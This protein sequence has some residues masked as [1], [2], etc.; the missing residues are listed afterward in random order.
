MTARAIGSNQGSSG[1]PRAVSLFPSHRARTVLLAGT[2]LGAMLL[3]SPAAAGPVTAVPV[4]GGAAPSAAPTGSRPAAP[5]SIKPDTSAGLAQRVRD[6]TATADAIR[7]AQAAQAAARAAGGSNLTPNGLSKGGLEVYGGVTADP[8]TAQNNNPLW[9]NAGLPSET[10]NADGSVTVSIKQTD[11]KATLTWNTF[12]VG[13]KTTVA[14]DQTDSAGVARKD[15][16]ALN[17]VED[18]SLAPSVIRGKIQAPGEVYIINRNGVIFS[19]T[20]QVN[21]AGLLASTLDFSVPVGAAAVPYG[22]RATADQKNIAFGSLTADQ[23]AAGVDTTYS[24]LLGAFRSDADQSIGQQVNN[25]FGLGRT[26]SLTNDTLNPGSIVIEAGAT[27]TTPKV[28]LTNAASSN[29]VSRVILVAPKIVNGGMI[30]ADQ[31]QVILAAGADAFF[32]D[33]GGGKL[34]VFVRGRDKTTTGELGSLPLIESSITNAKNGLIAVPRGDITFVADKIEQDGV[35]EVSTSVTTPGTVNLLTRTGLRFLFGAGSSANIPSSL[36]SLTLGSVT[37][38]DGAVIANLPDD[39]TGGGLDGIA[40]ADP[41]TPPVVTLQGRFITLGKGAGIMAPGGTVNFLDT[42]AGSNFSPLNYDLTSPTRVGRTYLG[43]NSFVDVSGQAVTLSADRNFITVNLRSYELRDSPL[44]REDGPSNVYGQDVVIDLRVTGTRDDGSTWVGTPLADVSAAVANLTRGIDEKLSAGGTINFGIFSQLG[45]SSTGELVAMSGS[46]LNVAGGYVSYTPGEALTTKLVTADGRLVDIGAASRDVVYQGLYGADNVDHPTWGVGDSYT[47][48]FTEGTANQGYFEG[49]N[50]GKISFTGSRLVSDAAIYGGVVIGQRQRL[51]GSTTSSLYAGDLIPTAATL[52]ITTLA[53]SSVTYIP[54]ATGTNASISTASGAAGLKFVAGSATGLAGLT[55]DFRPDDALPATAEFPTS[56]LSVDGLSGD[57]GIGNL[58][59]VAGDITLGK[60]VSLKLAPRGTLDLESYGRI[61]EVVDAVT[62]KPLPCTVCAGGRVVNGVAFV[63]DLDGVEHRLAQRSRAAVTTIDGTITTPGG[64]VIL[65]HATTTDSGTDR[66]AVRIGSGAVIDVSGQYLNDYGATVLGAPPVIGGGSITIGNLNEIAPNAYDI[67]SGAQLLANGGAWLQ[68]GGDLAFG[69]GGAITLNGPSAGDSAALFGGQIV[70][71]AFGYAAPALTRA[72]GK[73]GSLSFN[74][75]SGVAFGAL[76]PNSRPGSL[77]ID[78]A[79]LTR[80]GFSSVSVKAIVNNVDP[81]LTQTADQTQDY[82]YALSFAP[83]KYDFGIRNRILDA[84][85][86]SVASGAD[87]RA[88]SHVGQVDALFRPGVAINL[89]TTGR[90]YVPTGVDITLDRASAFALNGGP[91]LYFDG[92]ITAPASKIS[93]YT[94]GATFVQR[95]DPADYF[96]S[97]VSVSNVIDFG[98][99]AK[100]D[101]RG[102]ASIYKDSAGLRAGEVLAGGDVS[103]TT[104]NGVVWLRPGSEIDVSGTSGMV[105]AARAEDTMFGVARG[106]R[107]TSLVGEAGSVTLIGTEGLFVD[108]TLTG[109]AGGAGGMGGTLTVRLARQ[110]GLNTYLTGVSSLDADRVVTRTATANQ[111]DKDWFWFAP[112]ILETLD[113]AQ[114]GTS[115]F[116]LATDANGIR[117][118]ALGSYANNAVQLNTA[119]ATDNFAAGMDG[120]GFIAADTISKGGFSD[121]TLDARRAVRFTTDVT[122][123]P[124]RSLT[125]RTPNV[126]VIGAAKIALSATRVAFD[127]PQE[128]IGTTPGVRNADGTTS[129]GLTPSSIGDTLGNKQRDTENSRPDNVLGTLDV[130]AGVIDVSGNVAFGNGTVQIQSVAESVAATGTYTGNGLAYVTNAAGTGYT[131]YYRPAVSRNLDGFATINFLSATDIRVAASIGSRFVVPPSYPAGHALYT[132]GNL[133]L[134]AGQLYPTLRADNFAPNN[135]AFRIN[136][137]ADK[138][139]TIRSNGATPPVPYAPFGQLTIAAGTIDQGGVVRAPQG[140]IAL[141]STD[142]VNGK[143]ILRPGSL[144]SASLEGA[145]IPA[146]SIEDDG[147]TWAFSQGANGGFFATLANGTT[148]AQTVGPFTVPGKGLTISATNI[149]AQVGSVIDLSGGG[150]LYAK[151]FVPGT[152]GSVDVATRGPNR[153]AIVPARAGLPGSLV[154]ED[155]QQIYIGEGAGVPAGF[156]TLL[157]ADYATLPG[158]YL[159]TRTDVS[160][161]LPLY[162]VDRPDGA[163]LV[164]GYLTLGGEREQKW[165]QFEIDAP[166]VVRSR[167]GYQ[168]F[169]ANQYFTSDAYLAAAARTAGAAVDVP[170]LPADGGSLTLNALG[171]VNLLGTSRFLAMGGARVGVGTIT[172]DKLAVIDSGADKASLLAQNYTLLLADQLSAFFS[173]GSLAVAGKTALLV[174]TEV[175]PLSAAQI[176]LT[177]DTN[178]T[179]A[180]GSQIVAKGVFDQNS[181]D[182]INI[183]FVSIYAP[184]TRIGDNTKFTSSGALRMGGNA[185][186][187]IPD[188]AFGKNVSLVAREIDLQSTA[189]SLGAA[190]AGT[191]GLVLGQAA[192]DGIAKAERISLRS[193]G[194]ID[195]YGAV[196]IGGVDAAGLP[197]LEQLR[198]DSAG[199]YGYANDGTESKLIAGTVTITNT[200]GVLPTGKTATGTG[201]LTI[202]ALNYDPGTAPDPNGDSLNNPADNIAGD[203]FLSATSSSVLGFTVTNGGRGYTSPPTVTVS[204]GGGGSGVVATAEL[205]TSLRNLK[206]LGLSGGS[207][208]VAASDTGALPITIMA[209]GQVLGTI[210]GFVQGALKTGATGGVTAFGGVQYLR[211]GA[212]TMG[213]LVQGTGATQQTAVVEITYAVRGTTSGTQLATDVTPIAYKVISSSAGFQSDQTFSLVASGIVAVTGQPGTITQ[214]SSTRL[215]QNVVGQAMN[216]T[217]VPTAINSVNFAGD[218]TFQIAGSGTGAVFAPVFGNPIKSIKIVNSGAGFTSNPTIAIA[219]GG[220]SAATATAVVSDGNTGTQGFGK[221]NIVASDR[222]VVTSTRPAGFTAGGDLTLTSGALTVGSGSNYTMNIAGALSV[223]QGATAAKAREENGGALVVSA[224]TVDIGGLVEAHSGLVTINSQNG[225]NV[226][227]KIDTSGIVKPYYD[228]TQALDGGMVKLAAAKGDVTLGK[229]SVLDVSAGEGAKAGLIDLSASGT[230]KLDGTLNGAGDG[231]F[232]LDVASLTG[233]LGGLGDMLGKAGLDGQVAIRV[234]TGNLALGAGETIRAGSVTIGADAGNLSIAGTIDARR[235]TTGGGDVRLS[236]GQSLTLAGTGLV[237]ASGTAVDSGGKGGDVLLA[238]GTG[239]L[240]I[241][242]GARIRVGAAGTTTSD[243]GQVHLRALRTGNDVAITGNV[244]AAVSGAEDILVEPLR[245]YSNPVGNTTGTGAGAVVTVNN[246][247]INTINTDNTAYA[248]NAGAILAKL[249]LTTNPAAYFEMGAEIRSTGAIDINDSTGTI[250]LVGKR[251]GSQGYAGVLS[252]RAAGDITVNTTLTDGFTIRSGQIVRTVSN[253]PANLSGPGNLGSIP[254]ND[255]IFTTNTGTVGIGVLG[256]S[257]DFNFVAGADFTAA[258][259]M[260]TARGATGNFTLGNATTARTIRTGA[261]DINIAAAGSVTSV[262]VNSGIVTGGRVVDRPVAIPNGTYLTYTTTQTSLTL[263]QGAISVDPS[264]VAGGKTY[265]GTFLGDGGNIKIVAG[266]DINIAGNGRGVMS[267]VPAIGDNANA[268]EWWSNLSIANGVGTYGGGN[269]ELIAGGSVN[270]NVVT[271]SH[272]DTVSNRK[273]TAIGEL[274]VAGSSN[275][276]IGSPRLLT[277]SS[278]DGLKVGDTLTFRANPPG[279]AYANA[280]NTTFTATVREIVLDANGKPTGQ[281]RVDYGLSS[282]QVVPQG[283]FGQSAATSTAGGPVVGSVSV[284]TNSDPRVT[285]NGGDISIKARG[286]IAGTTQAYRGDTSLRAG[287]SVNATT[288]TGEGGLTIRANQSITFTADDLPRVNP[289]KTGISAISTGGGIT[290]LNGTSLLFTAPQVTLV[291]GAGDI[292]ASFNQVAAPDATFTL[293]ASG[294]I[295]TG[296]GQIVR[297]SDRIAGVTD[298]YNATTGQPRISM[299]GLH[300]RDGSALGPDTNPNRLYA[301]TGDYNGGFVSAKSLQLRAGRDVRIQSAASVLAGGGYRNA[302]YVTNV[303]DSDLTLIAAGRDIL[304]IRPGNLVGTDTSLVVGGP[305]TVELIA[306]RDIYPGGGIITN[307]NQATATSG[308]WSDRVEGAALYLQAGTDPYQATRTQFIDRYFTTGAAM[309]PGIGKDGG[310]LYTEALIAYVAQREGLHDAKGKPTITGAQALAIFRGYDYA[311]QLPLIQSTVTAELSRAG[312]ASAS[313]T[314]SAGGALDVTAGG[315]EALAAAFPTSDKE[316]GLSRHGSIINNGTGVLNQ[317]TPSSVLQTLAGGRMSIFAPYGTVVIGVP[318]DSGGGAYTGRGG[319]INVVAHDDIP[320]GDGRLLTVLGGRL[321]AWSSWGDI[322]AGKG[323]KTSQI[324]LGNFVSLD[325]DGQVRSSV[326][327]PIPGSGIGTLVAPGF[328]PADVELYAPHGVVDFGDAG[329]RASGNLIVFARTVIHADNAQVQG[330]TIGVP[331]PATVDVAVAA[332]ASGAA[333]AARKV[334]EDAVGGRQ[335]PSQPATWRVTFLGFGD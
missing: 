206:T 45:N 127:S 182:A 187:N 91:S 114:S 221:T 239:T 85:L 60:G 324:N 281:V 205:D 106:R 5:T 331:K 334:A 247:L 20:S 156:Y 131:S 176:R 27:I 284:Y 78:P 23:K 199:L 319:E 133:N 43:Q 105:D 57:Q 74:V 194:T 59:V 1:Q 119:T 201:S 147:I 11:A 178:V 18:P 241:A 272:S 22:T 219:G 200:G 149:D 128:Y 327:P 263:V 326:L 179:I 3:A 294:S 332:S 72:T 73:G 186:D 88:A 204:G 300:L 216:A 77:V 235:T 148:G 315:Y 113:V 307:G 168:E 290:F 297:Q 320:V 14:F 237:D 162:S 287:L 230:A 66:T 249:G 94:T 95:G 8:R 292:T 189:I 42:I 193:G 70:L 126:G 248:A 34:D 242:D 146:G 225:I 117:T 135:F 12:N 132:W 322:N 79:F 97:P 305:G 271:A 197:T 282:L 167:S 325:N 64:N 191:K 50:A 316:T 36:T 110:V 328:P 275:G 37:M 69:D 65:R 152:G 16:I 115:G 301:L 317:P 217:L 29:S 15:W 255:I 67:A 306:G 218:P 13:D 229:D 17:R 90:I 123:A 283:Y 209:N 122:L 24:G 184:V 276:I 141:I 252:F 140:T 279:T 107:P 71:E 33:R 87:L 245:I 158:A 223:V 83:G 129:I 277:L 171:T 35:L 2:A 213:T 261:G 80:G 185:T 198:L 295:G 112:L 270:A 291:A 234:R 159:V 238:A 215:G 163:R 49:K 44:Q 120:K 232:A 172:G 39:A 264:L 293:L 169:F 240:A 155:P 207:G 309:A 214:Q 116:S 104:N 312:R 170:V 222:V 310:T 157:P 164:S 188:L 84:S 211:A 333:A 260:A 311:N 280:Q 76:D 302:A 89:T 203:V 7:A 98:A 143:V 269:V 47:Q 125:L 56:Y 303:S 321:L 285:V 181:L 150:D 308:A 96:W 109:K 153:W 220:G 142:P 4:K 268:L 323:A 259:S 173:S 101:A 256:R 137:P 28:D 10:V 154:G 192:I 75:N 144:T 102:I 32:A 54:G 103:I 92:T 108:G 99:H 48:P 26:P 273:V 289:L 166:A 243:T 233:S 31:G 25:S 111:G 257:W 100:I 228:V 46:T 161:D 30:T 250:D 298:L 226:T 58:K 267:R 41:F 19:A 251:Y 21:T 299:A 86:R 81:L 52:S 6:L 286:N 335:P 262:N 314:A 244:G 160:S 318:G 53:S 278:I 124:S 227:G 195:F 175:Q 82:T 266:G 296:T 38:G 40:D 180:D 174:D 130:N 93:F 313:T 224:K 63:T 329:I 51:T 190:P 165:S 212:S 55:A 138:T 68:A 253:N 134:T 202:Q 288:Q 183:N 61:T 258:D 231:D 62:G 246:A 304:D 265:D 151:R 196:T 121:V 254:S 145:V 136:A 210:N 274:T 330:T 236:A 9:V 208:Y 177:S 118:A 139:I